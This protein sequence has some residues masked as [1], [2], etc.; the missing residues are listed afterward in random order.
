MIEL[1]ELTARDLEEN[2]DVTT[3]RSQQGSAFQ[4]APHAIRG[5]GNF[6]LCEPI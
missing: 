1:Q 4:V 3:R 2:G 5:Q 6:S